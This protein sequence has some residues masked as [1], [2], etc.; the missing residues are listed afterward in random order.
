MKVKE[1]EAIL[2]N[3]KNKDDEVLMT[4]GD[5]IL[6]VKGLFMTVDRTDFT[7]TAI[8]V[9]ATTPLNPLTPIL[10]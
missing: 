5:N 10:N 8:V 3:Y 1:L 2:A 7:T 9:S 6:Y 4:M